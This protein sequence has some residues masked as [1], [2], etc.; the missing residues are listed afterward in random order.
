MTLVTHL[1]II[2][3]FAMFSSQ[4]AHEEINEQPKVSSYVQEMAS[5][6]DDEP[7]RETGDFVR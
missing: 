7:G 5:P 3:S 2:F 4:K 6:L 1:L